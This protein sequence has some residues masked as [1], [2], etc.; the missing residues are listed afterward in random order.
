MPGIFLNNALQAGKGIPKWFR[1]ARMGVYLGRSPLHAR[2]VALV[3]NIKTGIVSPQFHVAFDD[4]F[5]T[6]N[7]VEDA[8]KNNWISTTHFTLSSSRTRKPASQLPIPK[9]GPVPTMSSSQYV[10][11]HRH[12]QGCLV[13]Q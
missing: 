9:G 13:K 7:R 2:S 1:R 5:E 10:Q 3:L 8:Y 12:H 4:M 11:F 6:V